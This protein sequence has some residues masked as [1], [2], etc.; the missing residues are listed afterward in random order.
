[1]RLFQTQFFYTMLLLED[2]TVQHIGIP[3]EDT[4]SYTEFVHVF[5]TWRSRDLTPAAAM[6]H[7]VSRH[8]RDIIICLVEN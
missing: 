4:V 8:N 1:M 7:K 6:N 3:T 5:M 2:S